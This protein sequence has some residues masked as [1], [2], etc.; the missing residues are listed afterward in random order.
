M[1]DL[2]QSCIIARIEDIKAMAHASMV[3]NSFVLS[4][5]DTKVGLGENCKGNR[6]IRHIYSLELL[7]SGP[8]T[9]CMV[10]SSPLYLGGA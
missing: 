7:L 2:S 10:T 9:L 3:L 5:L 8:F 1:V 6:D 4:I